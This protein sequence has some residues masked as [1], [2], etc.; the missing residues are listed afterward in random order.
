MD[1][2]NASA[3]ILNDMFYSQDSGSEAGA[4]SCIPQEVRKERENEEKESNQKGKG[5]KVKKSE[6]EAG[7]I[8]WTNDMTGN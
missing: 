3:N 5:K 1:S 7:W 6:P 2:V 8:N 4:A